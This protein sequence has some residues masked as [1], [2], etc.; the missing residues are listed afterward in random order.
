MSKN[1]DLET[2][3]KILMFPSLLSAEA[4]LYIYIYI[5]IYIL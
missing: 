4:G 1:P 2:N 3:Q 5:Y